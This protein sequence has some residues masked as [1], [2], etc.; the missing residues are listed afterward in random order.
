[1]TLTSGGSAAVQ[2][3]TVRTATYVT[4]STSPFQ[5]FFT[6]KTKPLVLN[7]TAGIAGNGANSNITMSELNGF[8]C[9]GINC[10]DLSFIKPPVNGLNIGLNVTAVSDPPTNAARLSVNTLSFV[11]AGVY[12]I[13]VLGTP[14][15]LNTPLSGTTYLGAK[16]NITLTVVASSSFAIAASPSTVIANVGTPSTTT[17]QVAGGKTFTGTVTL[18][19]LSSSAGMTCNLSPAS[20]TSTSSPWLIKST[21]SCTTSAGGIYTVTVT[22]TSGLAFQT[23][24]VTYI[25]PTFTMT[26]NP[27]SLSVKAGQSGTVAINAKSIN[28]FSG[29]LSLTASLSLSG[30]TTS[31]S[32]SSVILT[33][34]I[35]NSSTLTVTLPITAGGTYTITV[36]GATTV[37]SQSVS[38]TL[39]TGSANIVI[40]SVSASTTSPTAGQTVTITVIL[41]NTGTIAGNFSLWINWGSVKVAG[42][43]NDTIP[44][45]QTKTETLTWNTAG[46]SAASNTI[47]AVVST[48][49][50]NNG[51]SS[52]ANG[53]T[54]AL[55]AAPPPLLTATSIAIIGGIIAAIVVA[56]LLVLFLRRKKPQKTP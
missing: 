55:A 14:D 16:T 56:S 51:P 36:T 53:Q 43:I 2:I 54:V 3:T 1:V 10:V 28:G 17:V 24:I 11:P 47:I 19:T 39:T 40:T 49:G 25:S 26:A 48:N 15:T 38:I 42:P 18:S 4:S 34:G 30:S 44:A 13:Y 52:Q 5:P 21:L 45:G 6:F 35:T 12:T 23:A 50:G 27:A 31:L 33:P 29:T 46:F 22:G 20:L 37:I 7:Y 32:P 41:N 8:N 9:G